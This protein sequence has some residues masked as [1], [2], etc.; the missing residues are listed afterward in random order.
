MN[1]AE[2]DRKVTDIVTDY[3]SRGYTIN[4][5]TM[6]SLSGDEMGKVDVTNG[7]EVIR[8]LLEEFRETVEWVDGKWNF[9]L[10]GVRLVVG[11]ATEKLTPHRR[12][13]DG[14]WNHRL[15]II[16]E[17]KFYRVGDRC[18][19]DDW[20]GTKDE[21]I[22][23]EKKHRQRLRNSWEGEYVLFGE[24]AKAIVLP[25][26]RRQKNCKTATA[27]NITRVSKRYRDGHPTE[28]VVA[29]KGRDF[30]LT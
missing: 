27:K 29:Y 19:K 20:Y 21:A 11:R 25:F 23:R 1:S 16:S 18:W 2:L 13:I 24:N 12:G 10:P 26:L 28:Y 17:E 8:I 5:A 3:I 14:I 22:A 30:V 9:R 4:L 15:D 7:K 6:Q